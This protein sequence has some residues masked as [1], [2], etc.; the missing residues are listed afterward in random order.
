MLFCVCF[1][2][3]NSVFKGQ[4]FVVCVSTSFVFIDFY[5]ILFIHSS[6]DGHLGCFHF[7]S[8]VII[9][10]LF[11]VCGCMFI[12]LGYISRSGIAGSY[13]NRV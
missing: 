11:F 3:L 10:V 9:C 5:I 4:L 12:S 7:L 8:V 6:D 1:L 13:G 2:S